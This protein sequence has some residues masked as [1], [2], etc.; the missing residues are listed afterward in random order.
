MCALSLLATV[1]IACGEAGP[2]S[3]AGEDSVTTL[4]ASGTSAADADTNA[5]T[6]TDADTDADTGTDDDATTGSTE[7]D[8]GTTTG[9]DPGFGPWCDTPPACDAPP[10]P[11]GSRESWEHLDSNLIAVSGEPNHRVRDMFYVPG[12][13]Q[14]L[15][16]KFAYGLVDKDLKDE[17]VDVYV[18]RGCAGAW[19][20]LGDAWTTE[21]GAH[22]TVQGV[23][24]TGGWVYFELSPAQTL[25]LGR[26]RVHMVVRGD[27]STVD[28]FVEV[29]EPG[30]PIFVS[31]V[32]G[33]LTTFESEEF[34]D[35]LVGVLPDAHPFAAAALHLLQDK[36]Y[37]AMYLTA[38]PEW[39]VERTRQ[40]VDVR[41][42]PPGIIHTTLELEGALGSLA[43]EYKTG[44]LQQL[45]DKGLVPMWVFGNTD[46]DA[47]AYHNAGIQP[48]EQRVFLDFDDPHGGRTIASYND[49]IAEFG[50]LE[51]LCP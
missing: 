29:V 49:L 24:D 15:M 23:E 32:D 1:G 43:V 2:G 17:R 35:L 12:E 27:L 47:E 8:D 14:Y 7:T 21:E 31:D 41:G 20:L 9:E 50:A 45:A 18:Q 3:G 33:T 19:E 25:E 39:L 10:P 51:D 11:P 36:G 6:E 42:F 40:F 44:E 13:T 16:G 30:T 48:L 22:P 5:D 28:G 46:S 38:R 34:V 37:H 26:H 4:G